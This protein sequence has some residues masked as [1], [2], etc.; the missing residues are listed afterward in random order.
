[1]GKLIKSINENR[2]AR[3]SRK[4]P[5][6]SKWDPRDRKKCGPEGLCD[7]MW[8]MLGNCAQE[9]AGTI[10]AVGYIGAGNEAEPTAIGFKAS[11]GPA[12]GKVL[13]FNGCPCCGFPLPLLENKAFAVL[14]ERKH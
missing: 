5:E 6:L 13:M 7:G 4:A 12:K 9:P 11:A 3:T 8:A 1:M 10:T 2:Q 14:E